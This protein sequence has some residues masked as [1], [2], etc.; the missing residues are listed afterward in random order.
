MKLNQT[1]G[2]KLI[3]DALVST[4]LVKDIDYTENYNQEKPSE[5]ILV[6]ITPVL[7]RETHGK[8][9]MECTVPLTVLTS[10]K[11]V[12][13]DHWAGG[14][15]YGKFTL[16]ERKFFEARVNIRI[17]P[18]CDVN[19]G[20]KV[21][22]TLDTDIKYSDLK[23]HEDFVRNHLRFIE[24]FRQVE[25]LLSTVTIEEDESDFSWVKKKVKKEK[26]RVTEVTDLNGFSELTSETINGYY[27]EV[28]DVK[29]LCKFLKGKG[30]TKKQRDQFSDLLSALGDNKSE[31]A[32]SPDRNVAER[33]SENT[34][35]MEALLAAILS[36]SDIAE[37]DLY[38]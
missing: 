14:H 10:E 20:F 4:G 24:I 1:Q 5:K 26:S 19:P 32:G 27:P 36:P 15:N 33:F 30:A 8:G 31:L 11:E 18:K 2:V 25:T 21:T 35:E 37:L 22:Y 12:T 13:E 28:H 3:V 9:Y 7:R 34:E 17:H 38:F 23:S 6:P 29:G 16:T